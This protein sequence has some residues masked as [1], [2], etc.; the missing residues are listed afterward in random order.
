MVEKH[1]GNRKRK[2]RESSRCGV[3]NPQSGI[4][5][6]L[7]L[8]LL[9]FAVSCFPAPAVFAQS[10]TTVTD[11]GWLGPD[12][13][14]A[15]GNIRIAAS[16][17]FVSADGY[18]VAQNFAV[19][20]P[21]SGG[22]YSISL[23]PTIGAS[24]GTCQS[25]AVCAFY[26]VTYSL[27]STVGSASWSANWSVPTS[28]PV[29]RAQVE[30]A[31]S[32]AM[33]LL[34][35]VAPNLG[36][37][38]PPSGS[39]APPAFRSM[40]AA[41]E[42][43]TT[44][45]ACTSGTNV[46]CSIAMQRLTLGWNG[47]LG[48]AVGGT[49]QSNKTAAFNALSPMTGLGSVIYG[50]A[51]GSGTE[52]PG[53]ST[54]TALYFRSLGSGSAAAAPSWSQI[55]IGEVNGGLPNALSPVCWAAPPGGWGG[56]DA[57]IGIIEAFPKADLYSCFQSL[58]NS[59]LNSGIVKAEAVGAVEVPACPAG[60]ATGC[61][62]WLS[63]S[64]AYPTPPAGFVSIANNGGFTVEGVGGS[65]SFFSRIPQVSI[66]AG[67]S[68]AGQPPLWIAGL[69]SSIA[70]KNLSF[71]SCSPAYIGVSP[72]GSISDSNATSWNKLFWNVSFTNPGTDGCGPTMQ[73]E[74][75]SSEID[76]EYS[77][78]LN[79]VYANHAT[80]STA[81]RTSGVV[82]FTDTG[83]PASWTTTV[84]GV[85]CVGLSDATFDAANV[86]LTMT[87]ANT[88]TYPAAGADGGATGGICSSDGA[89]V[90]VVN[91]GGGNGSKI[92]FNH[93]LLYGSGFRLYSPG[94]LNQVDM[95][96]VL[97]EATVAPPVWAF[98]GGNNRISVKGL[99]VVDWQTPVPGVRKESGANP[100]HCQAQNT[101]V[102]GPCVLLGGAS[103][104]V[105][106][107]D[108]LLEGQSG[109][110]LG[111]R[112]IGEIDI[113]RGN[114]GPVAAP[115]ANLA[116]QNSFGSHTNVALAQNVT[117]LDG[118][119][120]NVWSASTSDPLRGINFYGPAGATFAPGRWFACS[121]WL[122][123]TGAG[124]AGGSA[125]IVTGL[126]GVVITQAHNLH[127]HP[128]S[129]S[130]GT[131]WGQYWNAVQIG[132]GSGSGVFQ[133]TVNLTPTQGLNF[134][135]PMALVFPP[136]WTS[137]DV[138][139]YMNRTQPFRADASPGQVTILGGEQFGSDAYAVLGTTFTASG[140]ST[141]SLVGGATGGSF[142]SGVSGT[143]TPTITMGNNQTA[144]HGWACWPNDLTTPAD[145]LHEIASDS[146]T[147][148]FSG[149]TVSG[150]LISFGCLAY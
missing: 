81:S 23:I 134:A 8:A 110:G 40:V 59:G 48:L 62:I 146:T 147:V 72:T 78:L 64:V 93:G 127:S 84:P 42:P 27:S 150:D 87:G 41:D 18:S 109:I 39:A 105:D 67:G 10:K 26:R 46:I 98:S 30:T 129:T 91:K 9:L 89:Q 49:G 4:A 47:L 101:V 130:V 28:G 65:N 35:A 97:S 66:Q 118:V 45:N 140:C 120:N 145:V 44:V 6:A 148:T 73:I 99:S 54:A 115:F 108:P 83:H 149:T 114:F 37:F 56:N 82:T 96:D 60:L 75:G 131:G 57:N 123:A 116:Q 77:Q 100:D 128:T 86:T 61:G 33:S 58:V 14:L 95:D 43:G 21:V 144:K 103:P 25:P 51:N 71:Y 69:T 7:R 53:N 74:N 55:Q 63:Y 125:P 126:S 102:S 17:A 142:V 133:C 24:A 112:L 90:L 13:S 121:S 68:V 139:Q 92:A 122:Q 143:C 85:G 38:S 29:T 117:M 132:S 52:L 80:G 22:R 20:I 70:F 32:T 12:G 3:R 107:E 31:G 111:G 137:N 106:T 2:T 19:Q 36:L 16:N 141:T 124:F 94:Q 136:G 138:V 1:T 119:P 79:D 113:A 34:N 5:R 50:G 104:L 11:Q 135:Y 88:F 76:F 15:N